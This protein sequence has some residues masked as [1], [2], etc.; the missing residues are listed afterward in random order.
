MRFI[1]SLLLASLLIFLFWPYYHLYR[2][3]NALGR[4][5]PTALEPLVDLD[6]I[7]DNTK[8]RLAWAFGMRDS[9]ANPEPEP[10]RWLQQGLQRAGEAALED[11]IDL[12]WVQTQ[13]RDAVS[14]ATERRPAYL[15]AAVDF[16]MFESWNRFVI[17][18]GRLGYGETH[19]RLHLEGLTWK[20]TDIIR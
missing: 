17:R 11:T 5:D 19:V 12:G 3:D 18:L 20:V 10:L 15:L 7:R 1:V 8:A 4:P 16:A 14:A 13:L 6:A 2:L 9:K